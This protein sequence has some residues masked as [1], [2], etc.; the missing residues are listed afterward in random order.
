MEEERRRLLRSDA[1]RQPHPGA[2]RVLQAGEHPAEVHEE[3]V[4]GIGQLAE[5]PMGGLCGSPGD[6]RKRP[7]VGVSV[8]AE[9]DDPVLLA[10]HL[11]A[12]FA[13]RISHDE[14]R[15]EQLVVVLG[16]KGGLVLRRRLAVQRRVR[17]ASR[18]HERHRQR[19]SLPCVPLEASEH[20]RAAHEQLVG[21]HPQVLAE[22]AP[23]R[24]DGV[25][26][27]GR[28]ARNDPGVVVLPA[29]ARD[30]PAVLPEH[31]RVDEPAV[32]EDL[33]VARRPGGHPKHLG[34]FLHLE[35]HPDLGLAGKRSEPVGRRKCR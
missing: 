3:R 11:E 13:H 15:I 1:R 18:G 30:R 21:L 28:A 19:L 20:T 31:N 23:V 12:V 5:Q 10:E 9:R 33:I 22:V 7:K 8:G 26:H 27:L 25:L 16:L 35:Q 32:V 6:V 14:R 29:S 17:F 2:V 4:L 24:L 34:G